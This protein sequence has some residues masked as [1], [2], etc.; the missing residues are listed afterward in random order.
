MFGVTGLLILRPLA[1]LYG[2]GTR[3]SHEPVFSCNSSL[4]VTYLAAV[5]LIWV[6]DD[7]SSLG[8]YIVHVTV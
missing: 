4:S 5:L 3:I 6:G 7:Q 8:T 2:L 1:P